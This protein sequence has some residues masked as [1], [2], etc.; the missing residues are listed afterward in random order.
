MNLIL[1]QRSEISKD[2]KSAKLPDK[3]PRTKHI[4]G[5]LRKSDGDS[6]TIGIISGRRGKAV[7]RTE[8]G[9]GKRLEF[10]SENG[11]SLL[12]D[13][14]ECDDSRKDEIVLVVS[15][16]FPK[17]LKALWAQITSMGVTRICII[18][19]ALSDANYCKS[20]VL[21]PEVYR[22]LVEEGMSQ[23]CH[24]REVAVDVEVG[25]VVTR[26]ILEKL[27]LVGSSSDETVAI[28]LDCG[29]ENME[30]LPCRKVIAS[31]ISA[32]AATRTRKRVVLAIGSER[33][34]TDDEAKLFHEAGYESASL[35][36]SILRVDTAIIA[37]LGIVCATLDE[38]EREHRADTIDDSCRKR[39]YFS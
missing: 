18:R 38:L 32:A 9:D 34:W 20:S 35:G 37:G 1:F 36:P 28:F 8:G 31:N 7:V 19:G 13:G 10:G 24:L 17:R 39:K 15:L 14:G 12:V 29:D 2:G 3:D 22:P 30:P 11:W 23:G 6:V 5:H 33:G 16:P 21:T 25:Q 4:F 26:A 27:G